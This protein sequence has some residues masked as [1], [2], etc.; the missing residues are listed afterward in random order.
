[1]QAVRGDVQ[2]IDRVAGAIGSLPCIPRGARCVLPRLLHL[3][4]GLGQGGENLRRD[5]GILARGRA[6]LL[7]QL[8]DALLQGALRDARCAERRATAELFR[9]RELALREAGR[10]QQGAVELL[11]H[12]FPPFLLLRLTLFPHL[13]LRLADRAGRFLTRTLR[14]R[15]LRLRGRALRLTHLL[16]TSARGIGSTLER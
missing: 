3:R 15:G 4:A 16:R 12:L 7:E 8:L 11:H 2:G 14:L 13:L 1:Q 10:L 6:H 9:N 5:E